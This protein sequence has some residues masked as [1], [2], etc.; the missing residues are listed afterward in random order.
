MGRGD[1][2]VAGGHS[3][4]A[5]SRLRMGGPVGKPRIPRESLITQLRERRQVLRYLNRHAGNPDVIRLCTTKLRFMMRSFDQLA[6]MD[7]L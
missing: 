4:Q 2:P 6:R 1:Q 3:E 5:G 7:E